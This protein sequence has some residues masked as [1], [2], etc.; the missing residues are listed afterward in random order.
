MRI[1]VILPD[2]P[3]KK[4]LIELSDQ[5]HI[6]SI[7]DLVNRKRHSRAIKIALKK[8]KFEREVGANEFENLSTDLVLSAD[9]AHWD[10]VGEK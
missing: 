9:S 1:L 3:P 10:R 2:D 4:V 8:G 5:Q 7:K 6:N